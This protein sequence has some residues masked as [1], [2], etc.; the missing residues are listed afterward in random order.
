LW[1]APNW[2]LLR[3]AVGT[4]VAYTPRFA[5]RTGRIGEPARAFPCRPADADTGILFTTLAAWARRWAAGTLPLGLSTG[6]LLVIVDESHWAMDAML[7]ATLRRA[8]LGR[9]A[10]VGL[11]AT[12]NVRPDGPDRIAYQKTYADLCP[13]YLATPR[14]RQVAT[15]V[16]WNPI[17]HHGVLTATSLG[18]LGR[19]ANRNE[20]IVEEFLRGYRAGAYTKTVLFACNTR[21]ADTLGRLLAE[22]GVSVR[23]VHSGQKQ[24]HNERAL[25]GFRSGKVSVLVNVAM[26]S[27][28]FDV[29]EIDAVFLAC[30]TESLVLLAQMIGRGA[31]R[32]ATKDAFW[33]VEFND[34]VIKKA[35]ALFHAPDYLGPTARSPGPRPRGRRP[36]EHHHEPLDTPRFENLA[37][38]DL[39]GLS[40]VHD[41]TFGVEI[42]L[43]CDGIV[44]RFSSPAWQQ[45]AQ[46][47]L[48]C[49]QAHAQAPVDPAPAGYHQ[50]ADFA[51]WRVS[52]D[53]SAG[54]EIVSPIL[55]NQE[56]FDELVRVCAGLQSL[57]RDCPELGVDD[58]TG[59]HV[60][61]ATRLNTPDRLQ[62]FLARLT[63]LEPGLFTLVAPSR[64]YGFDGCDYHRRGRN[65]Y[66]APVRESLHGIE[67][68][69]LRRFLSRGNRYLSVN[70]T[71]ACEEIQTLEI[72]MHQ[73]ST[74]YRKI[75]PWICLWMQIF[76][77]SRYCWTGPLRVGRVLAGGNRR[78]GPAQADREDLLQLLQAEGI[79]LSKAFEELLR[80]RRRELKPF[81]ANAIPRRVA[82]WER[83]GWYASH[84]VASESR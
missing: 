73:G 37:I 32:T 79:V 60:T 44:P 12:P 24:A 29:P 42:E 41:Q 21:H 64:L 61:L 36:V 82:S 68:A 7:G 67:E 70:L 27:L 53:S 13:E 22:R 23:V 62:G 5:P 26:L 46:R 66:C 25:A 15:G 33:V 54:W 81:W 63:R 14:V 69:E 31:R 65:P 74:N 58:R 28:G 71:R 6:P 8:Y 3:Q 10:M 40:Y 38:E 1:V 59:L 16:E 34:T 83:A 57:L 4:L 77:H 75:L 17:L 45:I 39:P 18:D 72:R 51:R 55:V 78:I 56:G 48:A 20:L 49:L 47:I 11:S 19:R 52:H 30:P 84:P 50:Y 43:T 2:D 80:Q 9:A 35:S 76:N